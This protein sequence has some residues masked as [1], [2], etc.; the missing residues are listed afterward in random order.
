[1]TKEV[2][3]LRLLAK[4]ILLFIAA[5]FAFALV[6]P[7]VGKLTMYNSLF[8]GRLRFPYEQEPEF[9]FVGFN[10]PVYEDF[11]AM[12]GAHVVAQRKIE[13]EYRIFLLGDSATWGVTVQPGDMLSEQIN[14]RGLKTCDGR[15]LRVYNLGY[16]M[17]FLM[18][19]L[20]ILDKALEYQPDMILWLVTLSTFEPKTAETYF[21]LPHAERYLRLTKKYN[22][23]SP[24]YA[25]PILELSLF[26][27]TI[28]Q[29]RSRLKKIIF[30]QAMGVLWSATGIDNH[31][32]FHAEGN[33]PSPDVENDS[34]YGGVLPGELLL[35]FN[36]LRLDVMS[37]GYEMAGNVP[38]VLINEPIFMASGLNSE[39]RYN[40][41]YPHWVFDEYRQFIYDWTSEKGQVYLDYWNI[42]SP[43]DFAD[44]SFHRNA[45][46]E[47]HFADQLIPDLQRLA[48]P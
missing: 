14:K 31:E 2:R 10:A 13:N 6:D 8:P 34:S 20:L 46:G 19:D 3:P 48:C 45:N 47:K 36:D 29:Q 5:N 33:S 43:V 12:F 24:E 26:D 21:M 16:P 39:V 25:E 22:L 23:S 7:P 11:D 27:R 9:Y 44:A 40:S 38:V 30:N 42:L 32:G 18:R 15:N 35:P 37:A 41:V 17:S 28:I 1:M 4:A